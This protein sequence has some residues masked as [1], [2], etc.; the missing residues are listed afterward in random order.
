MY[1]EDRQ[2]F[3]GCGVRKVKVDWFLNKPAGTR[4]LLM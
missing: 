4:R 3:R 1:G 2:V